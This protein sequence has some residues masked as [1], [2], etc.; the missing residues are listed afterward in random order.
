MINMKKPYLHTSEII[1]IADGI[2]KQYYGNKIPQKVDVDAIAVK[3]LKQ[4]ILY[5]SFAE[6]NPDK[7]GFTADG[8]S[9]LC[10]WKGGKVVWVVF[11]ADTIVLDRFLLKPAMEMRRRFTLAHEIS[12]IILSKT[13][14]LH[15]AACFHTE[16]SSIGEYSIEEL[17]GCLTYSE[18]QANNM[19][20][21]ILLMS[22]SLKLAVKKTFGANKV[23]SYGKRLFLP[24]DAEKLRKIAEAKGVSYTTL[25][26][27]LEACNLLNIGSIEAYLRLTGVTNGS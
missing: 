22:D 26:I 12:H 11:P 14:P 27:Q 13:D 24:R 23:N 6:S 1:Q 18:L 7:M 17:R 5:E 8:S 19:A 25:C 16:Q 20:G 2:V 21:S 4:N 10:I 9:P 15:H 3:V